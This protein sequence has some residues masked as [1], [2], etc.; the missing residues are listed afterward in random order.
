MREQRARVVYIPQAK[1]SRRRALQQRLS[2]V[3][4]SLGGSPPRGAPCGSLP[5][6]APTTADTILGVALPYG[7]S[8]VAFIASRAFAN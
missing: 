2:Y 6:L 3:A 4:A 8:V 7:S 1:P 5:D